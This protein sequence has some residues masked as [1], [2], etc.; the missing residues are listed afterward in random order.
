MAEPLKILT[1]SEYR[2]IKEILDSI[3][4]DGIKIVS[5]LPSDASD[6]ENKNTLYLVIG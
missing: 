5:E 2:K 4:V 3:G 1:L 6:D